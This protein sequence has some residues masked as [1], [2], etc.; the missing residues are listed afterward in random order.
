MARKQEIGVIGLG[1]FGF[2]LARTL[3]ELGHSVIGLDTGESR[4]RMARD[5]LTQVFQADGSDKVTLQQLGVADL[6]YVVVSI[7][8]SL[9][10]SVLITL[11]LKEMGA[12]NV[13]VK[14]ISEDHEK[15]LRKV[16]A[17]FVVFPEQFVAK[18]LAHRLAT[19]GL[20]NYMPLGGGIALHEIT[21]DKW[22]G[23]SLRE[24]DLSNRYNIQV[25]ARKKPGEAEFAFL[26][27]PDK[28]LDAGDV[29]VAIGSEESLAKVAP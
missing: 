3:V 12:R 22:A 25:V 6:S 21:V 10:A 2:C 17:D 24:L 7:G 8:H 16:G 29:L 4:V 13:W 19:P 14:A 18:Q 28:P 23:Q 15:V 27:P 9:E 26:L 11:N 1:K 20:L 5:V